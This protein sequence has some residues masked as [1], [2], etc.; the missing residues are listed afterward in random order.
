MTLL[1]TKYSKLFL[2]LILSLVYLISFSQEKS[3]NIQT[4]NN[5]K[6]YIH[7]VEKGQSLYAISK[8][9]GVDVNIILADNDEAIDG[10]KPGQD[11]KILIPSQ[12]AAATT[13]TTSIIDTN[14][15]V[16]HKVEKRETI[17]AISKKYNV[18]EA[19]LL[20]LNP[21]IASGIK[22]DQL[23]IISEKKRLF[24]EIATA[25][26]APKDSVI[27]KPKK[28]GYN[29]GLFLPFKLAEL[30]F[31]DVN[32][33]TQSK[34][35]FPQIQ[36][37]TTDFYLGFRRAVDSL[38][39]K[40]FDVNLQ[41]YDVDDKDSLKLETTCKSIDFK[42]LDLIVGPLYASG[43]KVVANYAKAASIPVVSPVTQ[44]NKILYKN[45]LTSKVNPSQ[46]TL[47]ESLVEYCIDSLKYNSNI[48]I[49][50]NGMPKD[51]AYVKAFKQHYNQR[52]KELNKPVWDS[53]R[54]V[55]GLAG[56]KAAYVPGNRNVVI[57]LTNNLVYLTDF[58]TQLAVYSDKKEIVLAGW[59]N[60]TGFENIDQEYLNKLKYT[61]ASQNNLINIKAYSNLIKEYQNE[62]GSDP[63]DYF[64]Q[65][66]DIAQYYM[67]SLKNVGPD[68]ANQLDKLP[69]E[70]NYTRFKFFRPDALTG[71]ENKGVYIFNYSNYQLYKTGWK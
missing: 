34:A 67:Q 15:Y 9:Y 37:L 23:I 10:L 4:I 11:L 47:L 42:S 68:F 17:Y 38:K 26:L 51:L 70:C 13:K 6:Y 43:F 56:F 5:K 65:G 31:I 24:T 69:Y 66:F 60:V 55:K 28:A 36:S 53:V 16:Y 58:I 39:S 44:Q 52:L 71:F 32:T 46:Y 1:K 63:S 25:S 61:F 3:T 48:F 18:T 2:T 12:T 8:I 20:E 19:K 14:R 41:L 33:L 54:E 35:N 27:S 29:V 30:D 49:V 7:K 22:K 59:Q 45:A 40:D 64:F 50:N 62:M 57:L 21:D